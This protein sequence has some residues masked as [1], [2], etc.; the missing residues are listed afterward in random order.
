MF[1]RVVYYLDHFSVRFESFLALHEGVGPVLVGPAGA[2]EVGG[3]EPGDVGLLELGVTVTEQ[4]NGLD[5][6][7]EMSILVNH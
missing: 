5:L 1:G 3:A 4:A 2:A 7:I 6:R